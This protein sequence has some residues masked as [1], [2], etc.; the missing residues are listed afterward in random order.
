MTN[1]ALVQARDLCKEYGRGDGPLRP[2]ITGYGPSE[3][4][5]TGREFGR[6]P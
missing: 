5:E 3:S 6:N 4:G 1:S 2:H